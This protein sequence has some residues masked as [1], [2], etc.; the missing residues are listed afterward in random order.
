MA[1]STKKLESKCF[2]AAASQKHLEQKQIKELLVLER[3]LLTE[4]WLVVARRENLAILSKLVAVRFIVRVPSTFT[5]AVT[6]R[7]HDL[8]YEEQRITLECALNWLADEMNRLKVALP[9]QSS[10]ELVTTTVE[11]ADIASSSETAGSSSTAIPPYLQSPMGNIVEG[12]EMDIPGSCTVLK[13]NFSRAQ[14]IQALHGLNLPVAELRD[15]TTDELCSTYSEQLLQ[16]LDQASRVSKLPCNTKDPTQR[17]IMETRARLLQ[18]PNATRMSMEQLCRRIQST[19]DELHSRRGWLARAWSGTLKNIQKPPVLLGLAGAATIAAIVA[20]GGLSA[21]A[22]LAWANLA[23]FSTGLGLATQLRST[24]GAFNKP[25]DTENATAY[26]SGPGGSSGM[27]AKR[28]SEEFVQ[29]AP[30]PRTTTGN[31]EGYDEEERERSERMRRTRERSRR[32]SPRRR[33]LSRT[34]QNT[35]SVAATTRRR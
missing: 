12:I 23:Q 19:A 15:R 30:S 3:E 28:G 25:E 7:P 26:P 11:L 29:Q 16:L 32:S 1:T 31:R 22:G 14:L 35:R 27:A 5:A 9:P 13:Q 4:P 21:A 6:N 8:F 10:T 2:V 34:S 20:S 24:V 33:S 18:I 17:H